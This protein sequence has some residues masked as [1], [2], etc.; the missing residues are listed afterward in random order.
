MSQKASARA[1]QKFGRRDD[2]ANFPL[3]LGRNPAA[4]GCSSGE[5][6]AE[7]ILAGHLQVDSHIHVVVVQIVVEQGETWMPLE[8]LHSLS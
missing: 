6:H 5:D 8:E 2:M 7:D 3:A 4:D 1:R